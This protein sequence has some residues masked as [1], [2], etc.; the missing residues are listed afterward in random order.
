MDYQGSLDPPKRGVVRRRDDDGDEDEEEA[1][2]ARTRRALTATTT[3]LLASWSEMLTYLA[4]MDPRP[5]GLLGSILDGGGV[6]Q[7]DDDEGC[8]EGAQ[9]PGIAR[10]LRH[11]GHEMSVATASDRLAP[12]QGGTTVSGRVYRLPYEK[13]ILYPWG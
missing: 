13:G 2:R 6:A 10:A 9:H 1:N 4:T 8:D 5:V 7:A 3:E 12:S 11:P